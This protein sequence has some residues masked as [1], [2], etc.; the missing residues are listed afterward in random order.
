MYVKVT[1]TTSKGP[2]PVPLLSTKC[3]SNFENSIQISVCDFQRHKMF[4][5]CSK[6][7]SEATVVKP[8]AL[9]LESD[10][11][12]DIGPGLLSPIGF[13]LS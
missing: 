2:T 8:L 4:V 13:I 5:A 10:L 12:L 1:Q 7:E 3:P 6:L 11:I 9:T